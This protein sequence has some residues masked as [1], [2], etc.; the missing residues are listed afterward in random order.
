MSGRIVLTRSLN[1][2]KEPLGSCFL[3]RINGLMKSNDQNEVTLKRMCFRVIVGIVSLVTCLVWDLNI[4]DI[5]MGE[6]LMTD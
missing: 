4:L 2:K 6:R 3:F 5:G 1:S